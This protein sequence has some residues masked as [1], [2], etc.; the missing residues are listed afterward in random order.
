MGGVRG[1]GRLL[2]TPGSQ[3]G[4][5]QWRMKGA[6]CGK[7]R[8]DSRGSGKCTSLDCSWGWGWRGKGGGKGDRGWAGDSVVLLTLT[9]CHSKMGPFPPKLACLAF[10]KIYSD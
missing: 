8:R 6:V 3:D 2:K 9:G 1:G 4:G 10:S 5:L 7:K